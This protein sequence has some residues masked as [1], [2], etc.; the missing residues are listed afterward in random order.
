M[1]VY[2]YRHNYE[3]ICKK[4]IYLM[5]I[6]RERVIITQECPRKSYDNSHIS[7]LSLLVKSIEKR[8][9]HSAIVNIIRS[10]TLEQF[11]ELFQ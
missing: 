8:C 3:K 1:L 11:Q 7:S 9:N 10:L 5:A 2:L 4:F 6:K